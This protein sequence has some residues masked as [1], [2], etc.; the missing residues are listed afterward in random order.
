MS[1]HRNLLFVHSTVDDAGLSVSAFR[2]L[3]HLERRTGGSDRRDIWPAAASMAK[4]CRMNKDTVWRALDEL[5][6]RGMV[7]REH[8]D[9]RASRHRVTPPEQWKERETGGKKCVAEKRGRV[10]A[11]KEG[12][13]A[14]EKRGH[15]GNQEKVIQEY[16]PPKG[17]A[18]GFSSQNG[19]EEESI[20]PP[21]DA[22]KSKERTGK[23]R[24][25]ALFAE[26]A[27]LDG[28]D[29][30]RGEGSKRER[31]RVGYV[32][33][34]LLEVWPDLT[35]DDIRRRAARYHEI[36]PQA[37]ITS[38]GLVSHWGKCGPQ[39]A[40]PASTDPLAHPPL[41]AMV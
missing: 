11:E 37:R 8:R 23:D 31:G 3:C 40:V 2:V 32:L 20:P 33:K 18:R 9:G 39:P 30:A 29:P 10:M 21:V 4:V 17:A 7:R 12:R 13:E 25:A 19:S 24:R 38:T 36:F 5:I 22:K 6:E 16:L 14:A 41:R 1:D 34:G 26:L 15:E 27:A 35:P 28:W